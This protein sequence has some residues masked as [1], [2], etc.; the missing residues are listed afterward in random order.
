SLAIS[1]GRDAADLHT[2]ESKMLFSYANDPAP[3]WRQQGDPA[4]R[5]GEG[6]GL[7]MCKGLGRAIALLAL[8]GVLNACGGGGAGGGSVSDTS[9][10][11]PVTVTSLPPAGLNAGAPATVLTVTGSGFLTSSVVQW[12]GTALSTSYVSATSLTAEVPAADLTTPAS[13]PE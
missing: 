2:R 8:T 9:P 4:R 5:S 13:V 6:R 7:A 11:P 12:N 1:A 3:H 10:P